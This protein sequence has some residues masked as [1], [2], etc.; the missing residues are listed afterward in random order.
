MSYF[1]LSLIRLKNRWINVYF[2]GIALGFVLER[3]SF[4]ISDRA[5]A[6]LQGFCDFP[7]SIQGN[8][9]LECGLCH[10]LLRPNPS[11]FVIHNST[12]RHYMSYNGNSDVFI[13][14]STHSFKGGIVYST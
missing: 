14:P 10:F 4:R 3:F 12:I 5:S 13:L 1:L 9:G 6:V 11:Q 7:E 8:G 2:S